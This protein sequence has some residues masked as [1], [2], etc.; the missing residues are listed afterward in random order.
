LWERYLNWKVDNLIW[1]LI[2]HPF[3]SG[4]W[5]GV[6]PRMDTKR[7]CV[8]KEIESHNQKTLAIISLLVNQTKE[9]LYDQLMNTIIFTLAMNKIFI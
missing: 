3:L 9:D 4:V 1:L 5:L 7:V 8:S 6:D 2:G